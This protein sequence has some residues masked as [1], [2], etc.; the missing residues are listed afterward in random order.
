MSNCSDQ[1]LPRGEKIGQI[2]A[3]EL[4]DGENL[5]AEARRMVE[6]L[7]L[8][9]KGYGPADVRKA[10]AFEVV[11]GSETAWS[12]LD[13]LVAVDGRA[14]MII[15]CAAGSLDS[16]Q[17][18]AVAAARVVASPPVP[19]A[20][21]ADP[22]NALVLDTATGAVTGEGFGAIPLREQLAAVLAGQP[23]QPLDP[24]RLEREKRILLAFDSIK[25]SVPQGA[26]G[27]VQVGPEPNNKD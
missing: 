12:S 8:E 24:K 14:G 19:V 10:I 21:V 18:Q 2:I 1:N 15:K 23:G 20:V 13:F 26:D 16:R 3:Q 25:C 17:R 11:L 5:A 27:G 22:E 4:S 7:L 6:Y 9:K